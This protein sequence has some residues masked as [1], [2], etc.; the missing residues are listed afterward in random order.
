MTIV[1]AFG[2]VGCTH[3]LQE[4]YVDAMDATYEAVQADVKA[5]V[6]KVDAN[7]KATLKGWKKANED[8]RKALEADA[9]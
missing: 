3:N 2:L 6:Y 5:G 9:E 4:S 8:A 1:L 7:S